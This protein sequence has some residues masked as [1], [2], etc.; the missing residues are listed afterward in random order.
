MFSSTPLETAHAFPYGKIFRFWPNLKKLVLSRPD[1]QS[2]KALPNC[3][4]EFYGI[5]QEELELLWGSGE[6]CLSNVH[7][8]PVRPCASTMEEKL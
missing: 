5:Y 3:D 4:V 8:V 7:I 1:W 2:K 6:G